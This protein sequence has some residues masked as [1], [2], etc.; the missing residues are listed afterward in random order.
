MKRLGIVAGPT[1]GHLIPARIV[2]NEL[3][4]RTYETVLF[5]SVHRKYPLLKNYTDA[6]YMLDAKG[7]SNKGIASKFISI[8][9]NTIEYFSVRSVVQSLSGI[10]SFG[11]YPSI[12]ILSAALECG[13]PYVL[14]EQNRIP[15]RANKM[16]ASHAQKF[17]LG[18]PLICDDELPIETDLV[19]TPVRS[20]KSPEDD[21]FYSQKL[22]T[23]LGGSQGSKSL[24]ESLADSIGRFFEN[25]WKIYYVRGEYG[26]DLRAQLN[27]PESQFRQVDFTTRIPSIL[28]QSTVCWIRGGAGSISEAITYDVPSLV[29]PIRW[30]SDNHQLRNAQ[31]LSQ[32][33]PAR[34]S[35]TEPST[36]ELYEKTIALS[37]DDRSYSPPWNQKQSARE[38]IVNE[39]VGFFNGT[40]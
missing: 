24:S 15:G 39:S 8:I 19:G 3:S 13:V 32:I 11:G 14:H 31:W 23:V 28:S 26:T 27:P 35:S 40:V 34:I 33:G 4:R 10:V 18:L 7:W 6:Y 17:F 9:S 16:F 21:W 5:S 30:L 25:D 2:A 38:R 22:L 20:V 37:S 29:F 12:S 36:R 1:G